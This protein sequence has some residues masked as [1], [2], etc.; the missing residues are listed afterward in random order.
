[1]WICA[2]P[3][4]PVAGEDA[5]LVEM[6]GNGFDAHRTG[7]AVPFKKQPI[8]QPHRA[9]VQWVDL[10][11]LLDLRPALLGCNDATADRRPCAIPIALTSVLA[12]GAKG[13]LGVLLGSL[14]VE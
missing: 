6:A 12:H 1:V 5:T 14:F 13:V 3:Q 8:D 11:L 7:C 4:R 2:R 9:G 10:Q